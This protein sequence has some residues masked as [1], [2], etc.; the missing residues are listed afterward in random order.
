MCLVHHQAQLLPAVLATHIQLPP[1]QELMKELLPATNALT[2]HG[3][4]LQQPLQQ[5]VQHMVQ[6]CIWGLHW[7]Y[8]WGLHG[9]THGDYMPT[10]QHHLT[11]YAISC[12]QN[13]S[14]ASI[15]GKLSVLHKVPD[16][17]C[18]SSG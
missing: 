6:G 5:T 10:G 1:L 15:C 18:A 13:V 11:V 12:A 3:L 16:F 14:E 8:T 7:D 4:D 2:C 9:T 17:S